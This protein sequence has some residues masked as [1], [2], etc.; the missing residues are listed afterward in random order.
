QRAP[1]SPLRAIESPPGRSR[2]QGVRA[3]VARSLFQGSTAGPDAAGQQTPVVIALIDYGAGNLT[4]VR[5]ALNAVGADCFTP[6]VPEDIRNVSGLII[7]GVGH[8][9]YAHAVTS[10]HT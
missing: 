4:S 7:P 6:V 3:R 5:K 2:F 8:F 1:Q 10:P 9:E